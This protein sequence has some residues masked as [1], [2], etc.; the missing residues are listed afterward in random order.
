MITP[1]CA[2]IIHITHINAALIYMTL[3]YVTLTHLTYV[4]LVHN[5][6]ICNCTQMLLHSYMLH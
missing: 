5:T 2:I 4:A 3:I 1:I 6:L